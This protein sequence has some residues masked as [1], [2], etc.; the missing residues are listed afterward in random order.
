G[1]ILLSSRNYQAAIDILEPM[2]NKTASAREAYQKATYYRGLQFYNE[3]AFP[4][5]LSMFLR[6]LNVNEDKEINALTYYWMGEAAYELR[7]FGESVRHFEKFMTLPAAEKTEVYNFANYALGYAA[8]EDEKYSKAITYF[9]RFLR[10]NDKD[11]KTITDATIRLA[12]SY[13]VNK[14]YSS[15]LQN[16]NSII[17]SRAKGEDYA[18]FQRG[19]IQG[20]QDQDDA[21]IATMQ[22][23]LAKYPGSSYADD[24]G[25]ETAYTYFAKE[26]LERSKADLILLI[27]KYP[28]SSYIP[29]ALVTIGLVQAR[30]DKDDEALESFKKVISEYPTAPEAKQALESVKIIYLDRGDSNGYITYAN[31]TSIGNLTTA[32]QDNLTFQAAKNRYLKGETQNV[33]DAV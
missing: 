26:E 1:E 3:G 25:F 33:V 15:A 17:A 12:D 5:G 16:Y 22:S 8:F 31:S 23:L 24:A 19:M 20:L 9:E 21:K 7:K 14:N 28:R 32:E 10:G 27:A 2:P 13:F 30:Q 6:S 18:L 11:Q 29:R 4:N